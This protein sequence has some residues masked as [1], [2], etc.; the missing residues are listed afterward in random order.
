MCINIYRKVYYKNMFQRQY[1]SSL[2]QTMIMRYFLQR[3]WL[4][5]SV[6]VLCLTA[7]AQREL[8][9]TITGNVLNDDMQPIAGAS[10]QILNQ[11]KGVITNADGSFSIVV[12][13]Q[14]AIAL[15]FKAVGFRGTP[16]FAAGRRGEKVTVTIK[17]IRSEQNLDTVVVRNTKR[18]RIEAGLITIEAEKA[19]LNPSPIGGIE[20]LIKVLVGSNNELSSQYN[21]RGGSYDENLVYVND[22]EVFRPY[23][24]RSGQQEGLSFI[25]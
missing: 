1:L 16:L 6:F 23:L 18:D 11:N 22:F 3:L 9:A 10:V 24:V 13:A 17:L 8:T 19:L 7:N 4:L 12:P 15:V 5:L 25:N 14:K 2:P 20:S 21:V